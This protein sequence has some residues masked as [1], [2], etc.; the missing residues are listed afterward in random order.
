MN[1]VKE[2]SKVAFSMLLMNNGT[3]LKIKDSNPD[4]V[5]NKFILHPN[6]PN[7][8]NPSTT[9]RYELP[10][11][12]KVSL[13]I[14]NTLGQEVRTLVNSYQSSGKHEAMWNGKDV[15]GNAVSSGIYIY[16]MEAVSDKG[17][18]VQTKKMVYLK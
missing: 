4:K 1:Y 8:F 10:V 6:Y 5:K 11:N 16:R 9:I 3:V 18:F 13:K 14:Y 15:K 2:I 17:K 7:P 12:G